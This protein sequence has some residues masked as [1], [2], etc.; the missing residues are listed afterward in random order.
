MTAYALHL[1]ER[2]GFSRWTLA[3]VAIVALHA[4]IISALAL[5]YVRQPVGWNFQPAIAVTLGAPQEASSPTIQDQDIAIGPTMQ[6]AQA[7]PKEERKVEEKPP[8]EVVQPPP[9][10]Q[11]AD[12]TLPRQEQKID[13]PEPPP[14]TPAPVTSAP[15][16]AKVGQFTEAASHAYDDLVLGHLH[17]FLHYPDAARG[18]LGKVGLRFVLNREGVVVSSEVTKSSGN[19]ALDQEALEIVRRASPFP[20]FPSAKPGDDGLYAWTADFTRS[21]R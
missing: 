20:Q 6:Q 14:V 16:N 1:P 15:R 11:Q 10:Q 5:W 8:D 12:V 19:R 3:G 4:A 21:H 13:K 9:P 7:T 17:R 2:H 18:V